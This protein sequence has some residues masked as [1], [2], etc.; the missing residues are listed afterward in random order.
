[1]KKT[2]KIV[3]GI[4]V[5]SLLF[6]GCQKNEEITNAI[7]TTD[8]VQRSE[9]LNSQGRSPN[10]EQ[11]PPDLYGKVK[12]IVGNEVL[13]E[14]AEIPEIRTEQQNNGDQRPINEVA[15]GGGMGPM[16]GGQRPG[17]NREIKYTGETTT[18]LIPVGVPITSFGQNTS[19]QLDIG[20]IY[21]GTLLQIWFDK[22]DEERIIQVR[23]IQG[24]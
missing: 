7:Q 3:I 13:L 1:M 20:D 22:D 5:L 11:N 21:E 24:R 2:F 9:D 15:V 4:V 14:L 12:S 10:A 8:Q 6:A 19:K 23:I 16:P 18:L 17:G